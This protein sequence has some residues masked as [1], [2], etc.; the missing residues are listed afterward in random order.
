MDKYKMY[1]GGKFADAVSGKTFPAINPA[2]E[3]KFAE[4]PL[5]GKEDVDNAVAAARKAFPAWMAKS[6]AERSEV[7]L[8]IAEAVKPHI[9]EL[10]KLDSIDHGT[11]GRLAVGMMM[12]IPKDFEYCAQV[13][14]SF[15]DEVVTGHAGSF[16]YLQR[17]PVGVCAV[18]AP[19]N[20]PLGVVV[21]KIAPALAVGNTCVIKPPSVDST[22]TLKFAEIIDKLNLPAGLINV[23]TGPGSSIG[24]MLASHPDVDLVT[25][26]GSLE[27]GA[28]IM[29]AASKTV[30]RLTLELGGKNPFI[31][32]DDADIDA[33]VMPAVMT[34]VANSGQ[35]CAAPGR[36]YVHEKVYDEFVKKYV[37]AI[38]KIAYGDPN[39]EKTFMGP[40]VSA[41]H[42]DKLESYYKIGVQ[43]GAKIVAG[44]KRPAMPKGYYVMPTVFV[45]VTQNMRIAKEEIFGPVAVIIKFSDKDN[46]VDMAN[47][48]IY[49]LCASVW[50]KN[51]SKAMKMA[52]QIRA[53]AVWLNS[54]MLKGSDLPWG[55]FKQSGFGKEN[56]IL[57]LEEYTQ[58]KWVS[59]NIAEPRKMS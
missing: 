7:L 59:L 39:D 24:K 13:A 23:V 45:D 8:K 58:V 19:W 17:E 34:K 54:H 10:G 14:R 36:Y 16:N 49:G 2:T 11:P 21:S 29:E 48:N 1:I 50:S 27:T 41:E 9:Q 52:G 37:A 18:I 47:D 26:T 33:A 44:G 15:M 3:E 22:T 35:I 30:K 42:R 43:E 5:G 40:V 28:D 56:G 57:G 4:V 32:M 31:V 46:V 55:G 38:E 53:G 51:I 25:F 12:D 20:A 6:Q